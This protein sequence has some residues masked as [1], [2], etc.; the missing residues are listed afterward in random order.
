MQAT[1]TLTVQ[2]MSSPPHVERLTPGLDDPIAKLD[3]ALFVGEPFG[4]D[5]EL[6]APEAGRGVGGA[7][8]VEQPLGHL[9]E[10][11]VTDAMTQRV[12]HDLEPVKIEVQHGEHAAVSAQAAETL[13]NRSISTVRLAT[14]VRGSVNACSF[15]LIVLS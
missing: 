5:H 12:V 14:P 2:T 11:G 1:P 3:G 9:H 4:H 7:E 10:H 6:V 8:V 13:C 15:R